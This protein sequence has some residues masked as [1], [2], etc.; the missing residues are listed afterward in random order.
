MPRSLLWELVAEIQWKG[1]EGDLGAPTQGPGEDGLSHTSP[2][3]TDLV[4]G[5]TLLSWQQGNVQI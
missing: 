5:G 4:G 1:L 2:A 3:A